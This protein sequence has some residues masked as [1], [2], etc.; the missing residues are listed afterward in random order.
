MR[1]NNH[2]ILVIKKMNKN[3]RKIVAVEMFS[4][5]RSVVNVFA[6]ISIP[7][8]SDEGSRCIISRN[9]HCSG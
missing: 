9:R 1:D 7:D 2:L 4:I 3:T 8:S 6:S 5:I